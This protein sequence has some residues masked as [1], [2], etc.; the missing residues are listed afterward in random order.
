MVAQR[1]ADPS[2]TGGAIVTMS[3]VNAVMVSEPYCFAVHGAGR[4][5][6]SLVDGRDGGATWIW[7]RGWSRAGYGDLFPCNAFPPLLPAPS[8]PI[9]VTPCDSH[10]DPAFG[11][12]NAAVSFL[13][14][15][16]LGSTQAIPTI[17]GYNASKGGVN[18]LTRCMALALAPHGIRVNSVGPGRQATHPCTFPFRLA[19]TLCPVPVLPPALLPAVGGACTSPASPG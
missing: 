6:R 5:G 10:F 9:H 18:G 16:H 4:A 19:M 7:M 2:W 3:S 14:P 1:E 11:R 15:T 8:V 17:A 12:V 13:P